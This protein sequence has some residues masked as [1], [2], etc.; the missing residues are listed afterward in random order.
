MAALGA[1]LMAHGN[2]QHL[3]IATEAL[4]LRL[5][6]RRTGLYIAGIVSHALYGIVAFLLLRD[7]TGTLSPH[8]PLF[9]AT[10]LTMLWSIAAVAIAA[11]NLPR[12]KVRRFYLYAA[13]AMIMAWVLHECS[14]LSNGQAIVTV[15]WGVYGTSLLVAGLLKAIRSMRTV[16]L[17][18]LLVVVG[19]LFMVDLAS[20]PAIWR[21]LL[22]IGF[23]GVFLALSYWFISLDRSR[24]QEGQKHD[25]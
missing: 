12:D 8:I 22:F 24:A 3:A 25:E 13:H 17:V 1:L 2:A 20:V 6:W 23:G 5:L 10:G 4:V 9:N 19:K 15:I 18:T 11:L 14:R 7:L 16:G 21:I